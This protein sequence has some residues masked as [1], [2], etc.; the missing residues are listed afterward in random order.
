MHAHVRVYIHTYIKRDLVYCPKRP[1]IVSKETYIHTCDTHTR[2]LNTATTHKH[3]HT[4]Y[5]HLAD[6]RGAA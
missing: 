3:T 4:T 5:T 1:S 6:S 2:I